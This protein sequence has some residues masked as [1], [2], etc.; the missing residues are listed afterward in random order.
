MWHQIIIVGNL[1]RAPE[2]NYSQ[3]GDAVTN[4]NVAVDNS[5]K[6]SNGEQVKRS[7]WVRVSGW[8]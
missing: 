4:L 8:R 3:S 1:G 7:S 2:M 6:D 5:Y